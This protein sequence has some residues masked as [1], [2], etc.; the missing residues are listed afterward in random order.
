MALHCLWGYQKIGTIL[1]IYETGKCI[2]QNI[3]VEF[4]D[5]IIGERLPATARNTP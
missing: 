4:D 2:V 3:C 5:A 1:Q